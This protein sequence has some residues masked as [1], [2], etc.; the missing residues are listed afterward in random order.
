MHQKLQYF[1]DF[2]HDMIA[3]SVDLYNA[4]KCPFN[5][6]LCG[7]ILP[8]LYSMIGTV[9]FQEQDQCFYIALSC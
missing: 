5:Q 3:K 9:G 1:R 7:T 4:S 2:D 8:I 6:G